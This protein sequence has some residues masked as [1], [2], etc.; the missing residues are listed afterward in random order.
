MSFMI[1]WQAL[2]LD[3]F[4]CWRARRGALSA[5]LVVRDRLPPLG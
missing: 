3:G 5:R 1:S 4:R 2:T